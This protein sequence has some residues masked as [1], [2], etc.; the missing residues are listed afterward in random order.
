[1]SAEQTIK[2][3]FPNAQA[4]ERNYGNG[5]I[6]TR[7]EKKIRTGESFYVISVAPWS[8]EIGYGHTEDD[9]WVHALKYVK[10]LRD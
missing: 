5:R 4:E 10:C 9:A 7:F 3:H 2:V 8:Y 1:M 6:P